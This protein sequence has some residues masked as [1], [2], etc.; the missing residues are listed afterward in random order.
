MPKIIAFKVEHLEV[1][2]LREHE[3]SLLSAPGRAELL[4]RNSI[5]FTAVIDGRV[6][7]CGGVTPFLVSNA[8]IWLIPSIYVK[9]YAKTVLCGVKEHLEK[10][11]NQL[12]LTRM[13]TACINDELHTSWMTHLGFQMEGVKKNYYMGHDY[14][15]WGRV[16]E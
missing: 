1:M 11:A 5:C 9:N 3:Q 7:L 6:V 2:D 4:E 8:D 15:M 12:A 14:T 16:W 10:L 13:E